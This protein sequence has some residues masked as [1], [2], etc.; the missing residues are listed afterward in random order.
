MTVYEQQQEQ[1]KTDSIK[2]QCLTLA[3]LLE[4]KP[5]TMADESRLAMWA[6]NVDRTAALLVGQLGKSDGISVML[7]SCADLIENEGEARTLLKNMGWNAAEGA[8]PWMSV[9]HLARDI[10]HQRE[11]E[12]QDHRNALFT[13]QHQYTTANEQLQRASG[14]IDSLKEEIKEL[15]KEAADTRRKRKMPSRVDEASGIAVIDYGDDD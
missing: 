12:A 5:S 9:V 7:R 2:F 13:V 3:K 15:R 6:E 10:Q 8:S 14:E 4:S 1:K 11:R